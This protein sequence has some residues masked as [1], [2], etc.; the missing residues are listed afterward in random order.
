MATITCIIG[1]VDRTSWIGSSDVTREG[2]I[3]SPYSVTGRIKSRRTGYRPQRGN[4][5]EIYE[6]ASLWFAGNIFSII[7]KDAGATRGIMEYDFRCVDYHH[8]FNRRMFTGE[9]EGASLDTIVNGIVA[10]LGEGITVAAIPSPPTISQKLTF[11][12][13]TVSSIFKRLTAL[14]GYFF[15]ID[16][17]KTLTVAP[18]TATMAPVNVTDANDTWPN[19]WRDLTIERSDENKRNRQWEI[20]EAQLTMSYTDTYTVTQTGQDFFPT[21]VAIDKNAQIPVVTVNGNPLTVMEDTIPGNGA[22]PG[23]ADIYYTNNWLGV[24]TAGWE[25]GNPSLGYA[26]N[27]GDVVVIQYRGAAR[28]VVMVEDTVDQFL[29]RSIEGGSGIWEAREDHHYISDYNALVAIGQGRL[30]QNGVDS[31]RARWETDASGMAPGQRITVNVP[32][33]G[34]NQELLTERVS[35]R[36]INAGP[37]RDFF[38][39]TVTALGTDQAALSPIVTP[40]TATY[41]E[42]VMVPEGFHERVVEMARVGDTPAQLVEQAQAQVSSSGPILTLLFEDPECT[43]GDESRT[44]PELPD[45]GTDRYWHPTKW[46]ASAVVAPIGGSPTTTAL[47]FTVYYST[48]DGANWSTLFT[49]HIDDGAHTNDGV[50]TQYSPVV[51]VNLPPGTLFKA[52]ITQVGTSTAGGGLTIEVEGDLV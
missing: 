9:F 11:K 28:N 14:T 13:E 48:D 50:M 10:T 4:T 18:F 47:E 15:S 45:I 17:T 42:P 27:A 38:R 35:S 39:H 36:W 30:K 49:D 22:V 24:W 37:G 40:S 2:A 34:V 20:T 31:I 41:I 19:G 8:I 5:F 3:N 12:V 29:R 25:L 43:V 23:V 21:S 32:R 1:G 26:F 46:H 44:W 16:F 33:F 7:E 6:G 51:D 52:E